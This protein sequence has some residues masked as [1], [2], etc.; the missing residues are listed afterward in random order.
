M[1]SIKSKKPFSTINPEELH[2]INVLI[3]LYN[4]VVFKCESFNKCANS[5]NESMQLIEDQSESL[6]KED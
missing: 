6:T 5:A 1:A 3:S 4:F 2:P